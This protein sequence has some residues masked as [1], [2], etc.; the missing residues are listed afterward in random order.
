[1]DVFLNCIGM[2]LTAWQESAVPIEQSGLRPPVVLGIGCCCAFIFTV[3]VVLIAV[4]I[5]RN[6]KRRPQEDQE[7]AA[8]V[9]SD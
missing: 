5:V 7:Q 3:I 6:K 9:E 2:L 1:M 4:V 8:S